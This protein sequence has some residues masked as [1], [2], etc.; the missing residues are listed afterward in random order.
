M[1]TNNTI[2]NTA[3]INASQEQINMMLAF[4]Q[5]NNIPLTALKEV[6]KQQK[7][8]FNYSDATNHIA[9]CNGCGKEFNTTELP[10]TFVDACRKQGI[11]AEC[12]AIF[13]QPEALKASLKSKNISAHGSKIVINGG[14]NVGARLKAMFSNA[15][16]SPNFNEEI[17]AQFMDA[18]YSNQNLKFSSYPFV[19]D[20]TNIS[21]VEMKES[22]DYYK[23]FYSKPY[24][25][26]G[27]KIRLCSQIFDA[28]F[29]ACEREFKKLGLIDADAQY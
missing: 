25:I 5:Q 29:N 8:N 2:N 7:D 11:C 19:I 17:L 10:Q 4:M 27:Y 23:R 28:Q 12:A 20:I 6:A 16:K 15:I 9:V 3:V 1:T 14:K 24:E 26:L 21:E 13:A 18:T 22:R